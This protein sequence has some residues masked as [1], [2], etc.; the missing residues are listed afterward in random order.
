M[1]LAQNLGALRALCSEGIIRGHMRLH[2]SNFA[3]MAGATEVEFPTLE[4]ALKNEASISLSRAQELLAA[5]RSG[6]AVSPA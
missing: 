4:A 1:G 2:A 3:I 5:I 6:D